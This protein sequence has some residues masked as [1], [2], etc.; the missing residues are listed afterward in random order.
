MALLEGTGKEIAGENSL[1]GSQ[2]ALDITED[3][4]G[5]EDTILEAKVERV[6]K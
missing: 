4:E 5:G 6:Y 2:E 1:R 3:R